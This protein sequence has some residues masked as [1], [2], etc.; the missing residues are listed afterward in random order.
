MSEQVLI[1]LLRY[2]PSVFFGVLI[3]HGLVIIAQSKE[4]QR[5]MAALYR[6]IRYFWRKW[7][8]RD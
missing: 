1:E 6:W 7:R 2:A 3:G 8:N 4:G 5:V